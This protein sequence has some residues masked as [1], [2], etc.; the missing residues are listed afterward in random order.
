MPAGQQL[1]FPRPLL[2]P[3][4]LTTGPLLPLLFIFFFRILFVCLFKRV[5]EHACVCTRVRISNEEEQRKRGKLTALS[6]EPDLGFDLT[7]LR[8]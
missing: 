1:T 7:I 5:S 2:E 8:P 6:A 3:S 4:L